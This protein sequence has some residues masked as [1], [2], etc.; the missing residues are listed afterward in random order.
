MALTQPTQQVQRVTLDGDTEITFDKASEAFI[1][2]NFS[3]SDI[4]VSFGSEAV[5]E[6]TAIRIL[7]LMGQVCGI[8]FKADITNPKTNVVHIKGTGEVE[9]QEIQW[10]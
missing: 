8:N 6:D 7:P 9:V 2:K 10:Q 3:D 4:Y 1:V 5:D